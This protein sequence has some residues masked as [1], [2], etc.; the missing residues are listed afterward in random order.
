VRN[1]STTSVLLNSL[2]KNLFAIFAQYL[3]IFKKSIDMNHK[4]DSQ[5]IEDIFV[6]DSENIYESQLVQQCFDI[7]GVFV[8]AVDLNGNITLI[9][10]KGK[11]LL[12]YKKEN[13][14][15]KNFIKSFIVSEKQEKT[16]ELFI[17]VME[18]KFKYPEN[19]RYHLRT[20]ENEIRIIE[21]KNITI[22]DKESN[23]L[24]IL[25]SGE[26]VTGYLKNQQ[27]LQKDVNLYR[28]L[29]NNIPDINLYLFDDNLR[30][31]L[32][33]GSEMKNNGFERHHFEGKRLNEISCDKTKKIWKPLLLAA[34]Q[35]KKIS[36]EYK[37]NNYYYLI[38]VLPLIN[39][40]N[41]I[42]SGIAIT[43]NITDEKLT[44]QKLKK[45][46]EE[47]EKANRAKSEFLAR[48][49][50]EI[51][52]PL[53]A[54]LGFAEQLKQ[55]EL[56]KKQSEYVNIIDKSSEHLLSL[57]ND[58]LILS[59]I[60]ARQLNFDITPFKIEYTAK[61]VHDA[62]MVKAEEK[63]L[64]FTFDIDKKL[65][66]VL[67]G[68]SFRLRQILINMLS[69]AI[70]FTHSGYVELR[71]FIKEETNDEVKVRF[72]IIDTGIGI[73]S[74]NLEN[75]FKQFKQADS[76][77]T[78]KYG[79]TGLGLTICKNLIELQNGSLSV[80]SQKNIGT[81]FTFI[82]PYKKGRDIDILPEDLGA[83]DPDKLK[84]KK[85]LFVD[86]DS[87][88]RLLG[89]TILE[90]F[91]CSLEIANGGKEAIE[92]LN[93]DQYD[94]VLLD[95]HMPEI[96]GI[97]VADYLRF[98]K[99]NT[100]TKIV[101]VTAAVMKDDIERYYK[102]GINDFIVKPFKEIH[103]FNKMCELLNINTPQLSITKE[104]I[105]LKEEISPKAYSLDEVNAMFE[106]NKSSVNELLREFINNSEETIIQMNNSLAKQDW[107]QIGEAAHKL[108]PSY[109]HLKVYSI[110]QILTKLKE[111][112]LEKQDFDSIPHLVKRCTNEIKTLVKQLKEKI[113]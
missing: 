7:V 78:K 102:A 16:R 20:Q 57:I 44:E 70:K 95:I 112:I 80:T 33:E 107:M 94:I 104:E 108:L 30:F 61:Y 64:R 12:G 59:K 85:V 87:V 66:K 65:D 83:V 110:I 48:V 41:E 79:G 105:I 5:I 6:I 1:Y 76:S 68:D 58:I 17:S 71:C 27:N 34:L 84:N 54:I 89:K 25:I 13:V 50:H 86:D 101:A 111:D 109:R 32:A 55:T 56:D 74:E 75:I 10:R 92:K 99:N 67:L 53:N 29:A 42:Y 37:Y 60:E 22:R 82:L 106:N 11:E 3:I 93:I 36:T 23:I 2:I 24:G 52:T 73:N 39:E 96:S 98:K 81:T 9:N 62:L 14:I 35:G 88:N 100:E 15:G 91:N 18:S 45:S 97:D 90:K 47:A 31:I 21:A 103:L 40:N 38:W 72:D 63:N 43:Q 113:S 4:F 28:I 19:T 49:S 26:D 46:K 8:A 69:N 51:R 77:I